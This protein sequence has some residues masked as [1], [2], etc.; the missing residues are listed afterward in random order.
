VK[1]RGSK[2]KSAWPYPI[3]LD[4]Q[5]PGLGITKMQKREIALAARLNANKQRKSK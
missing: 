2:N 4:F 1:K 3:D 5:F